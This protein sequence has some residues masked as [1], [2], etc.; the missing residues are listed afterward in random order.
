MTEGNA[1]GQKRL[2][3]NVLNPRLNR[4]A[5]TLTAT[6]CVYNLDLV[7]RLQGRLSVLTARYNFLVNL[8]SQAFSAQLKVFDEPCGRKFVGYFCGSAI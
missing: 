3:L 6:N 5:L 2:N 1:L 8:H 4:G 7:I